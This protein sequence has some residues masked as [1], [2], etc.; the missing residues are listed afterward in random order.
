M[1]GVAPAEAGAG[2]DPAIEYLLRG[3]FFGLNLA[4]NVAMWALFTAALTRAASSTRVSIVNVSAN[5]VVTALLGRLVFGEELAPTWWVGAALLAAGNVVIGRRDE[6]AG[7]QKA[8]VAVVA[9][10]RGGAGA[11]DGDGVPLMADG[12]EAGVDMIDLD[13]DIARSERT[14]EA[15]K[16]GEDVDAPLR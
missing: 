9:S 7:G 5:F 15:L 6:G 8:G 16:K 14:R 13:E 10:E 11:D 1:F 2:A 12:D 4:F 3:A